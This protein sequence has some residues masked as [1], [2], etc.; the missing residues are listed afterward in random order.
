MPGWRCTVTAGELA[1]DVL[2]LVAGS[3]LRTPTGAIVEQLAGDLLGI[4][5]EALG[6]ADK[7]RAMLDAEY[8]AIDAEVDAREVAKVGPA[9]GGKAGT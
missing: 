3:V 2:D 9:G 5:V 8:A 7:V 6:G 4:L 1:A